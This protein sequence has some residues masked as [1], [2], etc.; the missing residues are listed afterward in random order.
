MSSTVA[1]S[2]A[3]T[4]SDC[5][6]ESRVTRS[7]L[8]YGVIAG[9]VYVLTSVLQGALRQGFDFTK[10]DWSTLANGPTGW[11]QSTNLIL[12]GA[13]TIAFAV[14]LRRTLDLGRARRV[15]PRLVSGFGLGMMLAGVFR[16]DPALGFPAGTPADA[17]TVSWHGMLHLLFGGLGF[18]SLI[19]GCLVLARYFKNRGAPGWAG[20]TR[21]TGIQFL[22][23]FLC[24]VAGAHASWATLVFTASV[25]LSF[26][27]IAALA[28]SRY[29]SAT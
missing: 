8:G 27:W 14:G 22:A 23:G 12:T 17:T 5:S 11:I 10:H 2:A 6:P 28:V 20:Y 25:V 4:R 19:A 18:L 1:D 29:R 9:P 16:A 13:M 24:I 7:L 26:A 3:R 15:A 21:F